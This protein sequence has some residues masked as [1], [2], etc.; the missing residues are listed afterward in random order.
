MKAMAASQTKS[1]ILSPLRKRQVKGAGDSSKPSQ[2]PAC[3]LES[4]EA[5]EGQR[6]KARSRT[7]CR[8]FFFLAACKG[9]KSNLMSACYFAATGDGSKPNETPAFLLPRWWMKF[10]GDCSSQ[11]QMPAFFFLRQLVTAASQMK[12][13]FFATVVNEKAADEGRMVLALFCVGVKAVDNSGKPNQRHA[14]SFL[15]TMADEG[16]QAKAGSRTK[17]PLIFFG[18]LRRQNAK[19]SARSLFC[20]NRQKQQAE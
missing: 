5:D 18:G 6:A 4:T 2:R 1:P 12:C 15:A 19:P 17:C 16:Q 10:A 20:S 3:L 8:S 14:F 11:S 7:K 9:R 13:L